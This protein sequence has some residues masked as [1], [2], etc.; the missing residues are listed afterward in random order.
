[1]PIS[2]FSV[3]ITSY[4]HLKHKY[5]TM[6]YGFF[7]NLIYSFSNAISHTLGGYL[8]N[9]IGFYKTIIVGFI[10]TFIVNFGFIFQQ[11]IWLCYCLTF[12]LGFGTGISTSLLTKNIT[13]YLPDKKG[14]ISGIFGFGVMIIAAIFSLSGEKLINFEGKT[15]EEEEIFYPERIAKNTYLYFLIG[16]FLIPIGL[17][18]GLLL[19]Y[20]YKPEEINNETLRDGE[21]QIN[22]EEK[23]KETDTKEE[24]KGETKEENEEEKQLKMKISKQKI[25]Q[26]IKTIRY[27]RITFISFFLNISTSYMVTTG[28][29][30]GALIGINGTALQFSGIIQTIFVIIIGPILGILVDKKGPLL[31]LR[32]TTIVSIFPSI[33]LGFFMK[34][35][36]ILNMLCN[37]Y[38]NFNWIIGRL[39]S[40]YNGYFWHSRKCYIRRNY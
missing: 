11:D 21:N 18:F 31:I 2:N 34:Y 10:I 25:K 38:F 29:T 15:L 40:F 3:Y 14:I 16:E 39:Y 6:H 35:T 37:L 4:I 13:L 20:E 23:E 19:T 9:L 1:M 32:I 26:V 5:V 27:W 12:V 22:L 24:K 36:I 17:I 30:F 33:F 28:R 7:I 8:E